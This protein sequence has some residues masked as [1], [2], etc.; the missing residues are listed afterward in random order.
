M[1]DSQQLLFWTTSDFKTE[2]VKHLEEG[3]SEII[4]AII[5]Q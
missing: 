1:H 2:L 4:L 5:P 3:Q